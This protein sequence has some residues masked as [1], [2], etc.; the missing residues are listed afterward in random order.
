MNT[1]MHIVR[2]TACILAVLFVF[3]ILAGCESD[4]FGGYNSLVRTMESRSSV[5][6]IN[7]ELQVDLKMPSGSLFPECYIVKFGEDA[8][9]GQVSFRFGGREYIYRAGRTKEDISGIWVDG[10][11]LGSS[12]DPEAEY[13]METTPDGTIWS[14]WFTDDVQY[15][16][17]CHNGSEES[18]RD[19]KKRVR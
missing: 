10:S 6:E 4:F 18:F 9:I 15:F 11:P 7:E 3:S 17:I 5:K 1:N 19:M 14:R 8:Q 2:K 13:E 16:L 12:L